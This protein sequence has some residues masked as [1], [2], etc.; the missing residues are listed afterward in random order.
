[1]LYFVYAA[2]KEEDSMLDA[3]PKEYSDYRR[4]TKMII[5]F[6]L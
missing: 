4:Q 2:H 6:V 3:L 5:P 1:L